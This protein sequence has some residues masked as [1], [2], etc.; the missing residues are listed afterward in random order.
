MNALDADIHYDQIGLEPMIGPV[1]LVTSLGM[2]SSPAPV[3]NMDIVVPE[4][5]DVP[6][7]TEL[8]TKIARWDVCAS[9]VLT[10]LL[11]IGTLIR[12]VGDTDVSALHGEENIALRIDSAAS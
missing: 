7:K 10:A 12:C 6:A 3:V 2:P 9:S 1:V 11:A 8:C 5:L 4:K